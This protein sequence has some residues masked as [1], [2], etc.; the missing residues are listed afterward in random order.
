MQ[1]FGRNNWMCGVTLL[2]LAGFLTGCED[3]GGD[4][5]N[6]G[7]GAGVGDVGS[8]NPNVYVA[9]GDSTVYGG[10]GGGDPFPPR[11]AAMTGRTVLN[12]GADSETTGRVLD[13]TS[14]VLANDKPAAMLLYVG[15]VDLIRGY[16]IDSAIDNLRAII[17]LSKANATIPIVATLLPMSASRAL[18]AA[19][20]RELSSRIRSLAA[21]EGARLVDLEARFGSGEGLMLDDG[22]HPNDAG[23]QLMANAYRD[24]L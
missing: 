22:L 18:W 1:I 14:S 9:M 7:D 23:N 20:A 3:G 6:G 11:L 8:N 13:R 2:W 16:S 10:N 21:S 5:N 15:P 19:G 4:G 12:Y 17:Q 24:A